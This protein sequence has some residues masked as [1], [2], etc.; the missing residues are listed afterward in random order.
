MILF[1]QV[2]RP[3]CKCNGKQNLLKGRMITVTIWLRKP[4]DT[5]I[6]TE[7]RHSV[8]EFSAGW[9]QEWMTFEPRSLNTS[10]LH[11]RDW[12]AVPLLIRLRH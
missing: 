2:T 3:P 8:K 12:S 1:S 11:L 9:L 5:A 6:L 4:V 7:M 10:L